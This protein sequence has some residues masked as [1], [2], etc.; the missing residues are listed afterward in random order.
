MPIIPVHQPRDGNDFPR[1]FIPS[2]SDATNP[3][4]S[5]YANYPDTRSNCKIG[6]IRI[7]ILLSDN[8]IHP[9]LNI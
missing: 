3:P 1:S 2:T 6:T 4:P 5:H 7:E 8:P 9:K